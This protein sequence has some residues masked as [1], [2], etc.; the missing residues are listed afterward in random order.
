MRVS[1]TVR[2]RPEGTVNPALATGEIEVGD[3]TVE[4]LSRAEPPPFPVSDRI[5]ADEMTRLRHRYV[6]LRRPAMQRNLRLRATVMAADPPHD[7]GQ[8][9]PRGGDAGAGGV[10]PRGRP[11]LRGAVPPAA[12]QVLRPAPE[13]P[14]V[15]AAAHGG[16]RRPLLPDGPLPAGRGPA[17]RPPVRVHPARRRGQLRRPGRRDRLHL[18]G[19]GGRHRGRRPGLP[20]PHPPHD[21]AGGPG[22]LR[23]RQA[24]PPLR[25]GAHGPHAG[26]RG[27]RVPGLPA[28]GGGEGASGCRA[29]P[30]PTAGPPSTAWSTGPSRR[31]RPAW[32]G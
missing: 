15:Q 19:G 2:V 18:R 14:A 9:L 23:H 21:V 20:G 30:R 6:D 10:H 16:R 11:R 31:G 4:I 12:G 27:H 32:C 24:R 3:C 28:A 22:E 25:H 29:G 8:R 26:V 5:D 1:G 17:G 13:P 7:G